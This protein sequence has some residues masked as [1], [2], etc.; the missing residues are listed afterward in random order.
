MKRFPY[1]LAHFRL[2][3]LGACLW[4]ALAFAAHATPPIS[5]STSYTHLH[6][7]PG[8]GGESTTN[9]GGTISAQLSVGDPFTGGVTPATASGIVANRNYTGNLLDTVTLAVTAA[10]ASLNEGATRQLA[11]T[12]TFDDDTTAALLPTDPTWS[13][14][15][16]PLA[17]IDPTGL[18]TADYLFADTPATARASY[19]GV[20]GELVLL[21]LNLILP[22]GAGPVNG[23]IIDGTGIKLTWNEVPGATGYR[24]YFAGSL[25]EVQSA[26][27]GSA[28]FHGLVTDPSFFI[29]SLPPGTEVYWRIDS[30][31]AAGV[32][33]GDA[34]FFTTIIYQPDLLIGRT[35]QRLVGND[36]YN[37]N[38]AGQEIRVRSRS[39]K[40]RSQAYHF[41]VQND[42]QVPNTIQIGR[43]GKPYQKRPWKAQIFQVSGSRQNVTGA[44]ARSG[45]SRT[46]EA[47]EQAHFKASISV[48]RST[49]K[50]SVRRGF[51]LKAIGGDGSTFDTAQS[52]VT[53]KSTRNGSSLKPLNLSRQ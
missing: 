50:K 34:T 23:T 22:G 9:A 13:V 53:L 16:G 2:P 49:H 44:F 37:G 40:F 38:S 36:I 21:V 43:K 10:P 47:G 11:A 12:P 14:A 45:I 8:T 26:T 48:R 27:I 5:S 31:T 20:E 51:A 19:D 52:Q 6:N 18:A 17:S 46:L 28:A 32:I 39:K 30:V 41:A 1:Y 15:A 25:A 42:G 4:L 3:A 35:P 33:P 24:V 7:A 29:G